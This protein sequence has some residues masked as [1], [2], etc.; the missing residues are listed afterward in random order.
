M[1]KLLRGRGI[2]RGSERRTEPRARRHE[3]L[4]R[5][6]VAYGAG[7]PLAR[8]AGKATPRA[9][10]AGG[11]P[12]PALLQREHEAR[13][14]AD[15]GDLRLHA[16]V[17]AQA[18]AGAHRAEAVTLGGDVFFAAGAFR[19]D[20]Y[21]GRRLIAHELAHA[22]QQARGAARGQPLAQEARG[23]VRRRSFSESELRLIERWARER[24]V[25]IVLW[26]LVDPVDL[27]LP[28]TYLSPR[29]PEEAASRRVS[30]D[31]RQ[32]VR[33]L[34]SRHLRP[35][36]GRPGVTLAELWNTASRQLVDGVLRTLGI[37]DEGA[38]NVVTELVLGLAESFTM[39]A[40]EEGIRARTRDSD[41][42]EMIMG[43]IRAVAELKPPSVSA[44][45]EAV[46]ART[47]DSNRTEMIME[48]IRGAAAS[49]EGLREVIRAITGSEG[50]L[51]QVIRAAAEGELP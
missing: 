16:G 14:G 37:G 18:I 21:A 8:L 47:R 20:T 2:D 3:T 38:R 35:S 46:Q 27:R 29:S 45:E 26:P 49:E 40:I 50:T 36:Q 1:K 25:G 24:P 17:E 22:V 15:L 12:L 13:L 28:L 31:L 43:V 34:A 19:P 5:E 41:Q 30:A 11:H 42:A 33:D 7:R 48:M 44:F 9:A 39:S 51:E 10:I 6:A 23:P 32:A 4:E